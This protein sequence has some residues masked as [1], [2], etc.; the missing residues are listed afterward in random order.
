M[1][2]VTDIL[3]DTTDDVVYFNE[4]ANPNHFKRVA[5]AI[6]TG[7]I[8]TSAFDQYRFGVE[9]V[10]PTKNFGIVKVFSGD[11]SLK[12]KQT[13]FGQSFNYRGSQVFVD[14]SDNPTQFL[15]Y[16]TGNVPT[17]LDVPVFPN[18]NALEIEYNPR[19][20]GAID[21]LNIIVDPSDIDS[22]KPVPL[23]S[24]GVRGEIGGSS[25]DYRGASVIFDS[26]FVNDQK[27][28]IPTFLD[29]EQTSIPNI[30]RP[31]GVI[32]KNVCVIAPYVERNVVREFDTS[33][34]DNQFRNAVDQLKPSIVEDAPDKSVYSTGGF[35]YDNSIRGIDSI[36]FGG[37]TY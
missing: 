6:N 20:D 7:S 34:Y 4:S 33:V 10:N 27:S 14:R 2:R 35:V 9:L 16:S 28:Y 36:A 26:S 1:A 18:L 12:F 25:P 13:S 30:P 22:Q 23:Y 8:D 32:N 19:F 29:S 37:Q 11:G 24:E 3:S 21:V 5:E 15:M 31:Y 17:L